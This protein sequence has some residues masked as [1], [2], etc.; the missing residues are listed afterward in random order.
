MAEKVTAREEAKERKRKPNFFIYEIGEI[1]EN[2]KKTP[3]N[4]SVETK[5]Q[6]HQPKKGIWKKLRELSMQ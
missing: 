3:G 6:Y 2:V 4:Y 5:K 1:T